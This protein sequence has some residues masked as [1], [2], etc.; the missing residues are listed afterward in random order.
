MTSPMLS[1]SEYHRR[2]LE[3]IQRH[4]RDNLSNPLL[5]V[6]SSSRSLFMSVRYAQ[7]VF[8]QAGLTPLGWLLDC[9]MSEAR[10][11]LIETELPVGEVARR[12]GYR[13]TAQFSRSFKHRTGQNPS[14][15]RA[16][17]RTQRRVY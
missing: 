8:A 6:S 9:R 3:R 10:R 2:D 1:T 13:D 4:L 17:A 16:R 11:L 7:K 15:Y 14:R 12:V 5:S